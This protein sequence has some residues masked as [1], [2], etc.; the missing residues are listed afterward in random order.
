MYVYVYVCVLYVCMCVCVYVYI[1]I[2]SQLTNYPQIVVYYTLLVENWGWFMALW[3][4]CCSPDLL[5][6]SGGRF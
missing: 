6:A 3:I 2:Y 4:S 1:Y 5:V